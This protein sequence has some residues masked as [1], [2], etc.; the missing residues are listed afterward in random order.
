MIPRPERT[1]AASY[2]FKYIDQ[3]PD[4]DILNILEAQ[5]REILGLLR[6]VSSEKSLHRYAEGKWTIRD[7]VAHLSDCE[8]LFVF[9]AFWFARGFEA[10]LPSFEQD[11]AAAA[12]NA[13]AREWS[14]L[15]AELE[16]VRA[17]T[18]AFFRGLAPDD[19][20]RQGTASNNPF[21]VRAMAWIAAGHVNH[22]LIL[23][24][25]RYL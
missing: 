12:A 16:A 4:G 2:Y 19:W 5:G 23:L 13:N 6:S 9:R 8:R 24:R 15:I 18:L 1:E 25:E 21:S 3:V 7:T 17:S 20:T 11:T 10:P 22:H 14:A